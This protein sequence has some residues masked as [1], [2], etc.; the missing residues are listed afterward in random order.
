LTILGKTVE[1]KQAG[2]PHVAKRELEVLQLLSRG[3]NTPR[4]AAEMNVRPETIVWYR[5]RLHKKF[6]VHNMAGLLFKA[7]EQKIL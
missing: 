4:I 1:D 2:T 3:Y 6:K 7:M 5:K